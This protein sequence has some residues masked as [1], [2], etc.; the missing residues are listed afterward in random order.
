[1]NMALETTISNEAA[2]SADGAYSTMLEKV[3][4]T[5]N[6]IFA[7]CCRCQPT[8]TTWFLVFRGG[9]SCLAWLCRFYTIQRGHLAMS[10]HGWLMAADVSGYIGCVKYIMRRGSPKHDVAFSRQ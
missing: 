7:L 2:A 3:L 1:M 4:R 9:G 6:P 5:L 8:C 10:N